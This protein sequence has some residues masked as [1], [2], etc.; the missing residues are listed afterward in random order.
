MAQKPTFNAQAFFESEGLTFQ[1]LARPGVAKVMTEDGQEGEF[2]VSSFLASEGV[3]NA[4]VEYNTPQTAL[5]NVTPVSTLDRL[6]LSFGNA[7]GGAAYLKSKFQD[8]TVNEDGK[9]LVKDQG[10]W[11]TIDP[12][13]FSNGDGWSFA[14]AI[15]DLADVSRDI[16]LGAG[17]VAGA[18]AGAVGTGGV[19]TIAGSAAGGAIASTAAAALGR[20]IGTYEATPEELIK[21]VALDT[22]LAAGGE[23]V[24]LGAKNA[25]LPAFKS[26]LGKVKASTPDVQNTVVASMKAG[27]GMSDEAAHTAISF[28]D[29]LLSGLAKVKAEASNP[30]S[31]LSGAEARNVAAGSAN[32]VKLATDK[33]MAS[34]MIE[35]VKNPQEGISRLWRQETSEQFAKAAPNFDP[36]LSGQVTSA[37]TDFS[38]QLGQLGVF[39]NKINPKGPS[40]P[41]LKTISELARDVTAGDRIEAANIHKQATKFLSQARAWEV[42]TRGIKGK[43][44]A[45]AIFEMTRSS[46]DLITALSGKASAQAS[47]TLKQ[48]A[49]SFRNNLTASLPSGM[50]E[51]F[52][53]VNR[54]YAERIGAVEEL[55]RIGANGWEKG[56]IQLAERYRA[57]ANGDASSQLFFD[58]VFGLHANGSQLSR[59]AMVS[60]AISEVAN[61]SPGGLLGLG[62]AAVK[63]AAVNVV[64][65]AMSAVAQAARPVTFMASQAAKMMRSLPNASLLEDPGKLGAILTMGLQG[66]QR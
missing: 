35:L 15:G 16:L 60:N 2:D 53:Q 54:R 57:K 8:A 9:L 12:E 59:Q 48:V 3:K 44:A 11:Q 62:R 21:D 17:Q 47:D 24:A 31:L 40:L 49:T 25:V 33:R 63:N 30:A 46:N 13:G 55:K 14:E 10:V 27:L 5:Q 20:I 23:T 18:A 29:E 37:V 28:N 64:P 34:T 38:G 51:G 22:I 65:G 26:F 1:G 50:Q 32:A 42:E 45:K 41:S 58:T 39:S 61:T 4:D 36:N 7:K 56:A 19:G 43:E 66:Y 52:I 6:K